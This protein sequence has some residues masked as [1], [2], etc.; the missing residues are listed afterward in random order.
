MNIGQV[1]SEKISAIDWQRVTKDMNEKGYALVAQFLPAQYCEELSRNMTT[2]ISIA[3]PLRWKGI[4]S[5]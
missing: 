2:P 5:D 4:V 1:I 3:R